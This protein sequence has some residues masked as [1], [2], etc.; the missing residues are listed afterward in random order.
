MGAVWWDREEAI[1]AAARHLG[2]KRTDSQIAKA[3]KSAING[4]IRRGMLEYDGNL[5]RRPRTSGA[6]EQ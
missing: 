1:V 3:F 6:N 5:I 2:F 4:A